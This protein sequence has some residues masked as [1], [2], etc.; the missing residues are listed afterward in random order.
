[1]FD[2][3]DV[4]LLR[5]IRDTFDGKVT[6]LMR[7]T[8]EQCHAGTGELLAGRL[9]PRGVVIST[10]PRPVPGS[11]TGAS[12]GKSPAHGPNKPTPYRD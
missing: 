8:P 4:A 5:L 2:A 6:E 3:E 9:Q 11:L 1:V 12:R 10:E 7:G